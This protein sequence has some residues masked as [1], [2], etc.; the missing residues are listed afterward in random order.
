MKILIVDDNPERH[1]GFVKIFNKDH[2]LVH[3]W[4]YSQSI[5]YMTS[6]KFDFVCLDHDLGDYLVPKESRVEVNSR[7]FKL[8]FSPDYY[9]DTM[10]GF[11]RKF[12][13][14]RDI[15]KW[16]IKNLKDPPQKILI[17]SWNESGAKEMHAILS[18]FKET[19]IVVRRFGT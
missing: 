6:N 3:A 16:M 18:E 12:Y 5:E 13:D 1:E 7:N 11:E 10:Y 4:T 14:G 2:E 19:E 9:C 17:H 8:T 15:A